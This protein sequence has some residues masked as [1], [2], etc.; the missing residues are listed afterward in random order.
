[1]KIPSWAPRPQAATSAAGVARPSAHGHAMISTASPALTACP[2]G[3]PASSHPA[4]VRTAQPSTAGTNTAQIRSATRWMAAFCAWACSTSLISC[5]S[6]VSRPVLT[7]RTTSRPVSATVPAMTLSPSTASPGTDSPV[8]M[9][10]STALW[11]NTTSPSA[12]MASPG[13][14]T[15]LSPGR[16]L[17]AGTRRSVPSGPSRPA[18]LAPAAASS[19]IAWPA[20]RRARAS[21]SR[22]ASRNVVTVA[23]V[24]R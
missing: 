10:R 6:W 21:Y 24:S 4:R 19:R 12:A 14:T 8:I 3:E 15:N 7:A 22:P 5:E 23:A 2:A 17:L 1:M 18:S 16:R 11:P 9:L 20:T 13:R